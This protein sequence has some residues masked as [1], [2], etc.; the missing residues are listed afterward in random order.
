MERFALFCACLCVGSIGWWMVRINRI[1]NGMLDREKMRME[2]E[3]T[4]LEEKERTQ[5]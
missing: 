4:D 1:I 2:R 5:G 3:I